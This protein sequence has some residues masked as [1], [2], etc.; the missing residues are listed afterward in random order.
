MHCTSAMRLTSASALHCMPLLLQ[1]AQTMLAERDTQAA[2][3][4]G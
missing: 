2:E 3:I 4:N 1:K